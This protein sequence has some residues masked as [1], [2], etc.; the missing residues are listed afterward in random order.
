MREVTTTQRLA[1]TFF[2]QAEFEVIHDLSQRSSEGSWRR[3]WEQVFVE[4]IWREKYR[5]RTG[6]ETLLWKMKVLVGTE[7]ERI[8]VLD[9]LERKFRA[10]VGRE[11]W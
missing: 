7:A 5:Q 10:V 2:K 1:N 9:E 4:G 6:L 11:D 8:E 3:G